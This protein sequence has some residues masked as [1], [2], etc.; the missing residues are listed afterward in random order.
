MVMAKV[1]IFEKFR[2]IR[3]DYANK[4]ENAKA[5]LDSK[6][7]YRNE[8]IK[9][10]SGAW[11][12]IENDAKATFD[13]TV[14]NA[15]IDAKK[16]FEKEFI[17][18]ESMN[19]GRTRLFNSPA[20]ADISTAIRNLE[21]VPL[22]A[23]EINIFVKTF[24]GKSYWCDRALSAFAEKHGVFNIP[25]LPSFSQQKEVLDELL[26]RAD[27]FLDSYGSDDYKGLESL[28]D[29]S[30]RRL[31]A[32]FTNDVVDAPEIVAEMALGSIYD[33]LVTGGRIECSHVLVNA[34]QTAPDDVRQCLIARLQADNKLP[35]DVLQR[36]GAKA[37][38]ESVE[39]EQLT[40]EDSKLS[41]LTPSQRAVAQFLAACDG[42]QDA[43]DKHIELASKGDIDARFIRNYSKGAI[44]RSNNSEAHDQIRTSANEAIDLLLE[45][46]GGHK[47]AETPTVDE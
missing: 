29:N 44:S 17:E 23:N 47:D 20:F 42:V 6:M 28:H 8:N 27:E 14:N 39:A 41:D 25:V 21:G 10:T 9:P 36:T 11:N 13:K 3:D 16:A 30:M 26:A 31:L 4:F 24:A 2:K 1:E 19:E 45:E 46:N 38:F 34:L 7:Q 37:Y 32:R 5:E 22:D 12:K 43:T 35:D 33:A 15:K 40:A 18:A